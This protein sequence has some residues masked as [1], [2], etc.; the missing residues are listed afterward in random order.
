MTEPLIDEVGIDGM[1]AA[2]R[3][4]ADNIYAA[5]MRQ[6]N[7]SDRSRQAQE[8]RVGVSD[9]GFCSE[10]LRRFLDQQVPDEVDMLPAFHGTWLGEGIEQAIAAAHPEAMIQQTVI[11]KLKGETNEYEIEGHPD[12]VFP[13]GL[14]IDCKSAMGLSLAAS[15]G[16]EDQGRKYQRHNYALGAYESGL[17]GPAV[18][19]EDI[20]VGNLW[21]DRSAEE[22]RLLVKTEPFSMDVV[23][24]SARWLDEVVYS[25]QH[26]EEAM[27]EPPRDMCAKVCG[28][29]E[30]CRGSDIAASG[31]LTDPVALEA[32]EMVLEARA[33]ESRAKKMKSEA[34]S[35]LKG[36]EGSTGTHQVYWTTVNATKIEAF[37]RQSYDTLKITK[38]PKPK[39]AKS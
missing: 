17:F 16:M 27:K 25:W 8:F 36:V 18:A 38:I 30:P 1:T 7:E 35:Q 6:M 2:E 37:E 15:H 12:V 4:I 14:L 3:T 21:V 31:L 26:K 22:R 5:M 34:R 11:V 24:E 28:F 33:L 20:R 9:L 23:E 29:Y 13:D 32:V 10:R 39:K 19:L